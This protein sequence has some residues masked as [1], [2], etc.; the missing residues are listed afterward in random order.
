MPELYPD[1]LRYEYAVAEFLTSYNFFDDLSRVDLYKQIEEL[2]SLRPKDYQAKDDALIGRVFR[3]DTSYDP[4]DIEVLK[5]CMNDG[6]P[7]ISLADH[8]LLPDHFNDKAAYM[9]IPGLERIKD[10]G[11][12]LAKYEYFFKPD[13][14]SRISRLTAKKYID[15]RAAP[16]IR[17]QDPKPFLASL[18]GE[19]RE[20]YK[21]FCNV[22]FMGEVAV[23]NFCL[24]VLSKQPNGGFLHLYPESTRN[25]SNPAELLKIKGLA[26]TLIHKM[27]DKEGSQFAVMFTGGSYGHYSETPMFYLP[28]NN[29][30]RHIGK[31]VLSESM[32]EIRS[33]R[34]REQLANIRKFCAGGLAKAKQIAYESPYIS[35][36]VTLS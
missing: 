6:I 22:D 7:V 27:L 5:F 21:D 35:G 23:V 33:D 26:V 14:L 36:A 34:E 1:V 15:Q 20:K 4:H 31:V 28:W 18:S 19:M 2:H 12:I 30:R 16:I 24:K 25:V 3:P 8:T 29:P 32:D 17:P 10:E 9:S 11:V 13:G